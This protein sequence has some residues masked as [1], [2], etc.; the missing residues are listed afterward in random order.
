LISEERP[1]FIRLYALDEDVAVPP[2]ADRDALLQA[3]D[4]HI[5]AAGEM[6]V[7]YKSRKA[8]PCRNANIEACFD[9]FWIR[10]VPSAE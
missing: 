1:Y 3:I 4:G 9:R 5:L 2:A 7:P 8:V 10:P 6:V